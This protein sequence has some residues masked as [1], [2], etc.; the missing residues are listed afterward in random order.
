MP[1]ED[2]G[3]S[4]G[5]S[6]TS[7]EEDYDRQELVAVSPTYASAPTTFPPAAAAKPTVQPIRTRK[8][9]ATSA[10]PMSPQRAP[11]GPHAR[12]FRQ[13]AQKLIQMHRTSTFISKMG[14][15]A[16]PGVDPRRNTAHQLYGHLTQ[17]CT[18]DGA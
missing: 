8:V 13:V 7:D 17:L 6:L 1:R 15:G 12:R 16:E 11:L 2:S 3:S 9:T 5:A 10:A 18:I 4:S 14:A